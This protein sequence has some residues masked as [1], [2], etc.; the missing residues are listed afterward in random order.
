MR[1]VLIITM[2]DNSQWWCVIDPIAINR[3]NTLAAQSG[4][5]D[6]YELNQFIC[7]TQSETL[8]N[9]NIAIDWASNNMTWNDLKPYLNLYLISPNWDYSTEWT[10]NNKFVTKMDI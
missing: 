6:P 9:Y 2:K 10:T 7:N 1:D 3:A 8:S 5:T 4:I